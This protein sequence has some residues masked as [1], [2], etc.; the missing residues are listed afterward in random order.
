MT[1]GAAA[2]SSFLLLVFVGGTVQGLSYDST[3]QARALQQFLAG[4]SPS[5]NH[6][7]L[8]SAANLALDEPTWIVWWAPGPTLLA[9]PLVAT[10][11][12]LGDSF[13]A[14]AVGCLLIGSLGWTRWIELFMLPRGMALLL[15]AAV[16]WV[17][18]AS[19][20][21]LQ[22]APEAVVFGAAPWLLLSTLWLRREIAV[23]NGRSSRQLAASVG[24]G[25]LLG[26]AYVLKYSMGFVSVG[27]LAYLAAS[28]RPGLR[29]GW[30][31]L[32]AV[33]I[34]T[35]VPGLTLTFL[36]QAL[37]SAANLVAVEPAARLDPES[38]LHLLANAPLAALGL[39]SMLRFL[40]LQSGGG[41]PSREIWIGLLG[42]PGAMTLLYVG[43]RSRRSWTRHEPSRLAVSSLGAS[44]ACLAVVWGASANVSYDGRHLASASLATLPGALAMGKVIWPRSRARARGLLVVSAALY[45]VAPPILSML[46]MGALVAAGPRRAEYTA[47]PSALYAPLLGR[48]GPGRELV[49]LLGNYDARTDVWY[50]AEPTA[51]LDL[52]G[53]VIVDDAAR[54]GEMRVPLYQVSIP[55]RVLAL[56]P[57]WFETPPSNLGDLVK[58]RFPGL[59][60]QCSPRGQR[61]YVSCIGD[62]AGPSE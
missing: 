51:A 10:G 37:G 18:Y 36:N 59:S 6:L 30:P 52:P 32:L 27:A 11:L 26:S 4:A 28:A 17:P 58:S 8:P 47:G 9:Y 42:L 40:A 15:S 49:T 56:Y 24:V 12:S 60:W 14:L 7:V 50:V 19:N 57:A 22:F 38:V 46:L 53:R 25:L 34:A 23:G 16:P 21:F 33:T 20:A 48:A 31:P 13:R 5:L 44:L 35:M 29:A 39:D 54:T 3:W 2:I 1:S 62:A 55:S 61:D 41:G 45:L 43:W